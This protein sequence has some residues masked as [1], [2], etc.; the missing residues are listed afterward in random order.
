MLQR[1]ER[2]GC[3]SA[4][5]ERCRPAVEPL[6]SRLAPAVYHVDTLA[7]STAFDLNT[8]RDAAGAVSLR[9]AIMAANASPGEDTIVLSNG[10]YA[11]AL[12]GPGEDAA[13]T[14]DLD[15]HGNVTIIGQGQNQTVLDGRQVER[16]FQVHEGTLRLEGLTLTGHQD[17]VKVE[18]GQ[19]ELHDVAVLDDATL[20][21]VA[22]ALVRHT[23]SPPLT[24]IPTPLPPVNG[25]GQDA[26]VS[27]ADRVEVAATS[28]LFGVGG[29]SAEAVHETHRTT[30]PPEKLEKPAADES[31]DGRMSSRATGDGSLATVGSAAGLASERD[32]N[33]VE[34][35]QAAQEHASADV[36]VLVRLNITRITWHGGPASALLGVAVLV[37]W[38]RVYRAKQGTPSTWPKA[39]RAPE[40]P[41]GRPLGRRRHTRG[42]PRA[43]P[44]TQRPATGKSSQGR[45]SSRPWFFLF[46]RW[47]S[48]AVFYGEGGEW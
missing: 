24:S 42:P 26:P 30:L 32:S 25:T 2:R 17:V 5:Q 40:R 34:A 22:S 14:G 7:D 36:P 39:R 6:E 48:A 47:R 23:T 44:R 12:Q 21:A 20:A 9:S 18:R 46:T 19:V 43:G 31:M 1:A 15:I 8:G 29:R 27:L 38:E 35:P 16:L 4:R 41:R 37:S 11:L 10:T 3:G 28:E 13:R 33:P 45:L